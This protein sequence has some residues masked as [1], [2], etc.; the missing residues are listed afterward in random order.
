V[1]R[2]LSVTQRQSVSVRWGIPLLFYF[3]GLTFDLSPLKRSFK[4]IQKTFVAGEPYPFPGT[5]PFRLLGT[6]ICWDR[7]N[8]SPKI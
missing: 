2:G 3:P 1:R 6:G 4:E 8:V 5:L 7:S